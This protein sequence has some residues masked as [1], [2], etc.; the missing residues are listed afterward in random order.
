MSTAVNVK[1]QIRRDTPENWEANNPVL[2]FGEFGFDTENRFL[3]VGDGTS[4]WKDLPSIHVEGYWTKEDDLGNAYITLDA[5]QTTISK[6]FEDV[7]VEVSNIKNDLATKANINPDVATIEFH[8]TEEW[9][10]FN[11]T[12]STKNKFYIYTDHRENSPGVKVGD[13]TAY[14]GDLPFI[15]TQLDVHMADTVSHITAEERNKWN[16]AITIRND[17]DEETLSF[18]YV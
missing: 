12:I 5:Q 14:V 18:K 7:A 10:A 2:A 9:K 16:T 4:A 11:S 1:I 8:T 6:A 15:D 13:G 3:K 17:P